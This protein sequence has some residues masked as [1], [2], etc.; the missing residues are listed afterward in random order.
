MQKVLIYLREHGF[1]IMMAGFLI[2]IVSLLFFMQNRYSGSTVRTVW[3]SLTIAGFVI[4]VLGRIC[5]ALQRANA[6]KQSKTS[7]E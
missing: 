5:V 4:Y 2:A 7:N 1:M 6:R 3:F